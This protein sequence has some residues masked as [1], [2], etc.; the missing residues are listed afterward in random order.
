MKSLHTAFA[1][2][3][4]SILSLTIFSILQT[5]I[6]QLISLLASLYTWFISLLS[7]FQLLSSSLISSGNFLLISLKA[8]PTDFLTYS[9]GSSF[10]ATIR[11]IASFGLSL[12]YGLL[13]HILNPSVTALLVFGLSFSNHSSM[14]GSAFSY[15]VFLQNSSNA[16]ANTSWTLQLSSF[17]SYN[18]KC[19]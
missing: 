2:A 12:K 10:K 6:Y 18:W 4:P 3:P 8:L 1:F 14:I 16:F 11:L 9:L 17:L 15:P 5:G 19:F 7:N 13:V